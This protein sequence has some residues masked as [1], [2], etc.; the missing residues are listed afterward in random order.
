MI[1]QLKTD[2][3]SLAAD[4]D[5]ER[6]SIRVAAQRALNVAAKGRRTDAS[7]A[8][9]DRYPKLKAKEA[10][11]AFDVTLASVENLRAV[12]TVSGRPLNI[13]RFVASA[14]VKRG[15]GGVWVDIKGQRKFI[16]H[17]W[18]RTVNGASVVMTAGD[19]ARRRVGKQGAM[20]HNLKIWKT[21]DLPNALNIKEI[22]EI[23]EAQTGERFDNEFLRQLDR[24]LAR[25]SRR[26]Q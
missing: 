14:N 7:R 4:L 25:Q 19:G 18:V 9:R 20:V 10:S 21:I 2:F 22:A 24:E 6:R 13:Y 16:P 3:A 8:L 23:L 15:S 1:I 26:N 12:V 17:A 11:D 5:L